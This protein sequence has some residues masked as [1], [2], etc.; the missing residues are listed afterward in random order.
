MKSFGGTR[1]A[2]KREQFELKYLDTNEEMQREEFQI[3]PRASGG[4]I[5]GILRAIDVAPEKSVSRLIS[6]LAKVMDNKDGLVKASWK[7]EPLE[8]VE[9]REASFR[10]PDGEIYPM[11]DTEAIAKFN[12]KAN[13][14]SRRRWD[15]LLNEDDDAI[16]ELDDL[17]EI[18]EWVIALSTERPTQPRA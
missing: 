8:K 7:L 11:T 12:D 3:I 5:V 1:T 13:W 17:T 15:Y 6:I 2:P 14:T 10:G 9:D 16:V 4:D 18:A